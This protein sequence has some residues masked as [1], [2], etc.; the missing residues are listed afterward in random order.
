MRLRLLWFRK[1][2]QIGKGTYF[3]NNNERDSIVPAIPPVF[4]N[5]IWRE[6][7]LR[8]CDNLESKGMLVDAFEK[9]KIQKKSRNIIQIS[10]NCKKKL[11]M[12]LHATIFIL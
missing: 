12:D 1:N 5:L 9:A 10:K 8:A 7:N 6:R 2:F 3:V 4:F 11:D